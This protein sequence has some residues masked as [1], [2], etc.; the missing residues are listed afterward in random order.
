LAFVRI[1][2][3]HDAALEPPPLVDEP[4]LAVPLFDVDEPA[5]TVTPSG[6][7]LYPTRLSALAAGAVPRTTLARVMR[8]TR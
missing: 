6:S 8:P 4:G 7:L 3:V 2:Y 1:G 5:L